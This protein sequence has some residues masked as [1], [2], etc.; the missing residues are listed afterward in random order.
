MIRGGKNC[1]VCKAFGTGPFKRC[2][3][4]ERPVSDCFGLQFFFVAMGIMGLLFVMFTIRDLPALAIDITILILF[5]LSI[6][7]FIA[8]KETNEIVLDNQLLKDL[9]EELELR[10][11]NRTKELQLVNIE[12]QKALRI[13]SEFLR[14]MGHELRS[15][16]TTILGYC[17][18][19]L[20]NKGSNLA[21]DQAKHISSIQREGQTLLSMIGQLLDLSRLESNSLAL[22]EKWVE[23]PK[24]I[25]D[26]TVSI[27]PMA[28]KKNI[29]ITTM[30][31]EKLSYVFAD[32]ER[33][34]Q[35]LMNLLSN[36]VKFSN[37]GSRVTVEAMDNTDEIV[38]RVKDS[39]IG[40]KE[41][42]KGKIFEPFK[43][44]DSSLSKRYTGAGIGLS[45]VKS[46]VEAH[47]GTVNVESSPGSGSS[48]SFTIPKSSK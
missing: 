16:L 18:V 6:L 9:N 33:V 42:D 44:L 13:K 47:G 5:M 17:E 21:E 30:I 25:S 24:V 23:L 1:V 37:P 29:T 34:K 19:L 2:I 32:P 43:Q 27:E 39:G 35:I 20:M 15:P 10:V 3:Y 31:D 48:F 4:C 45:I 8:N 36:A 22:N 46:L 40:I 11:L 38:V 41:E 14:N 26:A 28:S 12:L 7:G